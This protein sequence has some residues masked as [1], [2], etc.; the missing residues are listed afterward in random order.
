LQARHDCF[1]GD[2]V[3][4]LLTHILFRLPSCFHLTQFY[5]AGT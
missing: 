4:I 5:A 1:Q 2:A 3:Q